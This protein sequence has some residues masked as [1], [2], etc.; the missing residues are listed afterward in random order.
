MAHHED[1]GVAA[2]DGEA[3]GCGIQLLLQ[4]IKGLA[5]ASAD[6]GQRD[7]GADH[8]LKARVVPTVGHRAS[9]GEADVAIHEEVE[10]RPQALQRPPELRHGRLQ[11]EPGPLRGEALSAVRVPVCDVHLPEA[12]LHLR[13]AFAVPP[14]RRHIRAVAVDTSIGRAGKFAALKTHVD[15]VSRTASGPEALWRLLFL[16][17]Q[18]S[19]MGYG[20]SL[21]CSGAIP[22]RI[23]GM[24]CLHGAPHRV[25]GAIWRLQDG[26]PQ[27]AA[28]P[29]QDIAVQLHC[30]VPGQRLDQLKLPVDGPLIALSG[31][32]LQLGGELKEWQE[33]QHAGQERA[34]GHRHDHSRPKRH[35]T[36]A[37]LPGPQLVA[38]GAVAGPARAP[39]GT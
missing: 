22:R 30:H 17:L 13:G 37:L 34:Q 31:F 14:T 23:E 1:C 38:S 26:I 2:V 33:H 6:H 29:L 35:S 20:S 36:A 19:S 21:R 12:L 28:D 9:F 32:G 39:G 5:A 16:Q 7:V 18:Q 15:E 8:S 3:V 10:S 11:F 4:A 27:H 25:D 24:H